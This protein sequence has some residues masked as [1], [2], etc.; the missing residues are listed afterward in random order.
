MGLVSQFLSS[1]ETNAAAKKI[2]HAKDIERQA[3]LDK[4][5]AHEEI[6]A[7]HAKHAADV[8]LKKAASILL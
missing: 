2:Q 5:V 8:E 4:A 1:K 3:V 7:A 6:K